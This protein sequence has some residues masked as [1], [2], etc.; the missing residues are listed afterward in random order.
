MRPRSLQEI[1][2]SKK[3]GILITCIK[4]LKELDN[5]LF[6]ND[7]SRKNGKYPV[8]KKCRNGATWN[9]DAPKIQRIEID[10]KPNK[11]CTRCF[12]VQPLEN[13]HSSRSSSDGTCSECKSCRRLNSRNSTRVYSK[14]ERAMKNL[15]KRERLLNETPEERLARLERRRLS[16]KRN[17]EASKSYIQRPIVKLKK[18]LRNR[19]YMALRNGSRKTSAVHDLGCS[20]EHFKLYMR[21]LFEPGMSWENYG[22]GGWHIDH[23]IPLAKFDLNTREGQLKATHFTNLQPLWERDNLSKSTTGIHYKW[24]LEMETNGSI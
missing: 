17:P 9:P 14:E 4:C 19:L 6:H 21:S 3:E 24:N 2:N 16:R 5:S 20:L 10:G 13:F 7:C 22:K 23:I 18:N 8:C 15:K 12:I 1:S 11:S